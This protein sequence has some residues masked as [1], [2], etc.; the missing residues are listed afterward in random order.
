VQISPDGRIGRQ[1]PV[2]SVSALPVANAGKG[3]D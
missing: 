1:R 2:T 3:W